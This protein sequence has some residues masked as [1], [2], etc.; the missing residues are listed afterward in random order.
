MNERSVRTNPPTVSRRAQIHAAIVQRDSE[1][2]TL[3][4]AELAVAGFGARRIAQVQQ[5]GLRAN[6]QPLK[7]GRQRQLVR[8][9][10]MALI[11]ST[12]RS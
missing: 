5:L 3:L 2:S 10:T 4:A 8:R 6:R 7:L 12:V 1:N 11:D 9:P